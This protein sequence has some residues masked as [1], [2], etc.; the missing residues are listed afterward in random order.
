M[1]KC[2]MGSPALSS[3]SLLSDLCPQMVTIA[4]RW[5]QER[6]EP[7]D[8][9]LGFF[10]ASLPRCPWCSEDGGYFLLLG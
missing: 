9:C 4:L 2:G 6:G 7:W 5:L 8:S 3:I 10:K 1:S